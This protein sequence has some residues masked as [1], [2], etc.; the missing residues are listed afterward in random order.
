MVIRIL[1]RTAT[2]LYRKLIP[3]LSLGALERFAPRDVV[4]FG[5][6]LV[7]DKPVPYIRHLYS[8]KTPAEFEAD[9]IYLKG[10]YQLPTWSEFLRNRAER[11]PSR[12]PCAILSFDDGLSQCFDFVRPIL[13][14]HRVP[15]IFFICKGFVDNHRMFYRHKA[16]LCLERIITAPDAERSELLRH[17]G[18]AFGLGQFSAEGFVTWIKGLRMADEGSIDRICD[19]FD[20]DMTDE[21][22]RRKPYMTM[23]QIQQLAADGFTIGGHSLRHEHLSFMGNSVVEREIVESCKFVSQVIETN[24]VPFA[25]PFD[26]LHIDR[27]FLRSV[28]DRH[29]FIRVMFDRM[30]IAEDA[31]FIINR[32]PA[33]TP[34]GM[35]P[36]QSGLQHLTQKVYA[37]HLCRQ[38]RWRI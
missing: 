32:I 25:F 35:P 36:G 37:H 38:P 15:C 19:V 14:K 7:S 33:D 27:Q 16:S 22:Q 6:H 3:R 8:Y 18:E 1:K 2:N 24:D 30:N 17:A 4:G 26:G 5:Y 28:R 10:R 9:V 23:Q 11:R 21:L 13:L 12:R 34:S 20:L 29:P 31:P